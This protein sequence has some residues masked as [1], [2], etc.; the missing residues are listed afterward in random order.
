MVR[1]LGSVGLF[2]TAGGFATF[3]VLYHLLADWRATRMGRHVMAFMAVCAGTM[4]Y[5]V[6]SILIGHAPG[7][8][9]ARLFVYAALGGVVWWRIAL[10]I[11]EQLHA[12]RD[13]QEGKHRR[14]NKWM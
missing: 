1:M 11:S 14:A 3:V 9:W 12:R 8:D 2:I 5:V 6:A 10:L 7:R 13:A 4:T